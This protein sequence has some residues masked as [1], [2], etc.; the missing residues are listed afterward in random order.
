MATSVAVEGLHAAET[1]SGR[2]SLRLRRLVG[3]VRLVR[4]RRP[5]LL[6]QLRDERRPAGLVVRADPGAVVAV[7]V[8][9]E[10][11]EVLPVRVGLED[12]RPAEAGALAAAVAQEDPDQPAGQ[13]GRDFRERLQLPGP[14]R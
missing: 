14:A 13:L 10:K 5:A 11:N 12:V 4:E 1:F 6:D 9:M 2:D 7:E 3:P 8:F